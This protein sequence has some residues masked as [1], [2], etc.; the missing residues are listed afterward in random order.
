[1]MTFLAFLCPV[2]IIIE[3]GHAVEM[4]IEQAT[5]QLPVER[6]EADLHSVCGQ[7]DIRPTAGSKMAWGGV[8]ASEYA[9]LELALVATN[10]QQIIRT[11]KNV[12]QDYGENYFLIMQQEGRALMAQNEAK[13]LLMPGDMIFIDSTK[14]SEFTFFGDH[15]RQISLHLPR[16]EV[17]ERLGVNVQGGYSLSND[18]PTAKAIHA[19]I[20]KA[21]R[22]QPLAAQN[23]YLK[24]ALYGLLGM[25]LSA[26]NA[27]GGTEKAN[28]WSQQ[29]ALLGKALSYIEVRFR[30]P[31]F[32]VNDIANS[33]GVPIRQIQRAFENLG[34]TPT[35]FLLA[36][37][38]EFARTALELR[39]AGVRGELISGIAYSAGFSDLSYFN[40]RFRETYGCSPGE[41]EFSGPV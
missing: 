5:S 26:E 19:V 14:P 20:G 29:D 40:R 16:T 17:Y 38:L 18:D 4:L 37:R 41:Y 13:A 10:L 8:A 12:R 3:F 28:D 15:S 35:K 33:L 32:S 36:K 21:I 2:A 24:D 27:S 7:F 31:E 22:S 25:F 9:E 11:S 30:D 1:M 23:S 6:F 34:V 39:E